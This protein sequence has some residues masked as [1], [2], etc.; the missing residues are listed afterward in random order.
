V[1]CEQAHRGE[2]Q[3]YAVLEYLPCLPVHRKSYVAND[4]IE[5]TLH[6]EP[7]VV[8]EISSDLEITIER[9]ALLHKNILWRRTTY[10]FHSPRL[11]H[12]QLLGELHTVGTATLA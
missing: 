1:L 12:R 10:D 8:C 9:K 2:R 6:S 5:V 7:R 3:L 11:V 4:L